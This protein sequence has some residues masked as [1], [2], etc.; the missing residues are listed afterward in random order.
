MRKD[1]IKKKNLS[2]SFSNKVVATTLDNMDFP[3]EL[4]GEIQRVGPS[5]QRQ[6]EAV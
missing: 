1:L 4:K 6:S 2:Q 3:K 5:S